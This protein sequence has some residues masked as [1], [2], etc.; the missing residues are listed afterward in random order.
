MS[1]YVATAAVLDA[2]LN[3]CD[4]GE[5]IC[6]SYS[7]IKEKDLVHVFQFTSY[8]LFNQWQ[9]SAFHTGSILKIIKFEVMAAVG[10]AVIVEF[11]LM[12]SAPDVEESFLL[13]LKYEIVVSL[14]DSILWNI[15]E[16]LKRLFPFI[17][18]LPL[19]VFNARFDRLWLPCCIHG[20]VWYP[21]D[22][23]IVC[24]F[25][26]NYVRRGSPRVTSAMHQVDHKGLSMHCDAAQ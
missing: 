5:R 11:E 15:N 8:K 4:C 20:F 25:S 22:K 26:K 16:Y 6:F 17:Q 9:I 1:R 12:L 13:V 23:T 19:Y 14:I 3:V 7:P 18:M 10:K 24:M 21:H 2:S